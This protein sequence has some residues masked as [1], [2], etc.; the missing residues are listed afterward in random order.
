MGVLAIDTAQTGGRGAPNI[1][2]PGSGPVASG[3]LNW[4]QARG[5]QTL[6]FSGTQLQLSFNFLST[7][8]IMTYTSQTPGDCEIAFLVNAGILTDVIGGVLCYSDTSHFYYVDLN[9]G[10]TL[11]IGKTPGFVTLASTGFVYLAL[12]SYWMKFRIK[13]GTLKAKVWRQG[14]IEPDWMISI[15]DASYTSGQ[16]G[17]GAQPSLASTDSFSFF[18]ANDTLIGQPLL[19]NRYRVPGR[20]F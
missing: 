20:I 4:T 9:A 15:A 1:W 18:S 5:D 7:F 13:A 11:E 16:F 6:G 12:T 3:G 17:V 19:T 14:T 8:G 10:T 2:S